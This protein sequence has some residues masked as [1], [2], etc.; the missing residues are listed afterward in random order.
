MPETQIVHEPSHGE[1]TST[2]TFLDLTMPVQRVSSFMGKFMMSNRIGTTPDTDTTQIY[3]FYRGVCYSARAFRHCTC[4]ACLASD[5]IPNMVLHTCLHWPR[6]GDCW[7]HQSDSLISEKPI[8]RPLLRHSVF[9]HRCRTRHVQRKSPS[10]FCSHC[11]MTTA[12][13]SGRNLHP[14][15]NRHQPRRPSIC[16]DVP[17]SNPV[18]LYRL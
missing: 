12:N 1:V 5:Q 13:K 2:P 11:H 7:V 17:Q 3:P 6:H 8:R 15:N 9:L 14:D 4:S 18:D 16:P 10:I